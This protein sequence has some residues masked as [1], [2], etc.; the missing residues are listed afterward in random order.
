[1]SQPSDACG[2]CLALVQRVKAWSAQYGGSSHRY[3]LDSLLEPH[4]ELERRAARSAGPEGG[5]LLYHCRACRAWW[6]VHVWACLNDIN[7]ERGGEALAQEWEG[8]A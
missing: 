4:G 1:M 7:I 6:V 3:D 2:Q 5:S 8:R